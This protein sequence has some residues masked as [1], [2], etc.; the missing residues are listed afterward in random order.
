MPDGKRLWRTE[1][2]DLV[3]DAHP[4]AVLLAYGQDD[5]LSEEDEKLVRKQA[6]RS[7]N[8]QAGKAADKQAA[9]SV[10]K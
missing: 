2:G 1:K 8:K 4:E 9:A 6:A 3:E 10:N 5:A 7:T